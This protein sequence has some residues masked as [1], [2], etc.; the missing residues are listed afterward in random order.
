MKKFFE[1]LWK[2]LN[3][4]VF[5]YVIGIIIIILLAGQ[6]KT[7]SDLKRDNKISEQN[8]ETLTDSI[9]IV[10]DKNGKLQ[11]E[12]AILFG[13]EKDLKK[14]NAGLYSE[15]KAQKGQV[16]SLNKTVLTL[17][18]TIDDLNKFIDSLNSSYED[19]VFNPLDSTWTIPWT[20]AYTYDTNNYDIFKGFTQVDLLSNNRLNHISTRMIDRQSSI[21]L[22]FGQKVE[23]GKLRVFVQSGYPGLTPSSL[24]G[25][26]IDPNSNKYLRQISS[27]RHWFTGFGIG[28]NINLGYDLLNQKPAIF[29]G[30]GIHYNIFQW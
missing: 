21:S 1:R 30:V 22:T 9:Q 26:L 23:D 10:K 24:E 20:L 5:L 2:F 13:S 25:V 15:L 16:V 11:A 27:K 3:S 14:L 4:K 28:P 29:I 8:I 6:C 17:H 18:Q 7:N 19:P 12:K